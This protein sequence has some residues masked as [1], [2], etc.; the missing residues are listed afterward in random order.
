MKNYDFIWGKA[1]ND[2]KKYGFTFFCYLWYVVIQTEINQNI[3]IRQKV[4]NFKVDDWFSMF[5]WPF[6]GLESIGNKSKY[7]NKAKINK[8]YGFISFFVILW[9]SFLVGI[10]RKWAI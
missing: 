3:G 7:R 6:L 1:K 5:V 2:Q 4:N 10:N 8:I 9:N